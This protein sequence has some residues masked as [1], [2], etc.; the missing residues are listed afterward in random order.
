VQI[1]RNNASA[2]RLQGF[3]EDLGLKGQE[4]ATLVRDHIIPHSLQC[5]ISHS[6]VTAIYSLC[7]LYP[8]ADSFVSITSVKPFASRVSRIRMQQH[9]LELGR[10][11]IFIL[12][13]YP[14]YHGSHALVRLQPS[15]YL[16]CC[17]IVW[18]M[19]SALT[20]VT[21][22]FVG[23]LLTRFFLGVPH[24][25]RSPTLQRA[26]SQWQALLRRP[27]TPALCSCSPRCVPCGGQLYS[28]ILT[29]RSQWYKRDE[30]GFRTAILTCGNI[31]SNGFVVSS[32]TRQ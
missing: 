16:P 29:P 2:A 27:S 11:G 20:G 15:I 3:E 14:A 10:Q 32:K 23:A 12:T 25:S 4:F 13:L 9:V 5:C 8:H 30:I 22:N 7:R 18:G 26:N 31:I 24:L 21:H 28:G 6:T 1:D 17:M 19:I